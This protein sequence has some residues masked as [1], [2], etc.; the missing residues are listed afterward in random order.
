MIRTLQEKPLR[1]R[2]IEESCS[3]RMEVGLTPHMQRLLLI[4]LPVTR[5]RTQD[6]NCSLHISLCF[7]ATLEEKEIRLKKFSLKKKYY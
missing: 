3:V 1:G 7:E 2:S 6:G 5:Q 4:Y